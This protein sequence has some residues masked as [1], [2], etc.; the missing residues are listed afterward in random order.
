MTNSEA[1]SVIRYNLLDRGGC[2]SFSKKEIEA[3]SLAILALELLDKISKRDIERFSEMDYQEGYNKGWVDGKQFMRD[4]TEKEQ[5]ST[6]DFINSISKPT[7][8]Q[9]DEVVE[10]MDY[11]Q[12]HP[13]VKVKLRGCE[14]AVSRAY[15]EPIVEELE[16]I[17]ING[18]EHILSLLSD[19]KNAPPVTP[20]RHHGYWEETVVL[21][22]A[23]DI[24]GNKTWASQMRCN[25][26]EFATFAVE[27]K[28]SQYNFCPN[29]GADMREEKNET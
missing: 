25:K 6:S 26:C 11:V 1:V 8:L 21:P 13:K 7:G 3:L 12:E 10:E 27:G 29:C 20:T 15:I 5:K 19:I 23:Y 28:F 4:A 14:D 9:F 22:R 2:D 24:M 16:N 17:C 18:D